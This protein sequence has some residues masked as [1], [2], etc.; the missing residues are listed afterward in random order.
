M[1]KLFI[2]LALAFVGAVPS[3]AQWNTNS[4]PRSIVQTSRYD[5]IAFPRVVRLPDG[6]TW[7]GWRKWDA[8][9][10]ENNK[11]VS[12]GFRNYL[13]LLDKDGNALWDEPLLINDFESPTWM[14]NFDMGALPDGSIVVSTADS[15]YTEQSEEEITEG[16]SR[17]AF[18]PAFYRI[19]QEGNFLWGLNGVE[20]TDYSHSALTRLTV[21]GNDTY[22][23]WLEEEG[24]K[25]GFWMDRIS[26]DGVRQLAAPRQSVGK[27]VATADGNMMAFGATGDGATVM[28]YDRDLQPVWSEPVTYDSY[29]YSGYD[30]DPYQVAIDDEGGAAVSFVRNMGDFTHNVRVQ[31]IGT[32]GEL[33]F[34]LSAIDTYG[35]EEYDHDYTRIALNSETEEIMVDWEDKVEGGA[36]C[37]SLG[38]F[39]YYGDRLYGETGLRLAEKSGEQLSSGYA[40]KQIGAGALP[41][42]DWIVA[43]ADVAGWGN[44][45]LVVRRIDPDG[46]QVWKKTIGRNMDMEVIT[47]I[48]EP[49]ASYFFWHECGKSHPGLN[50]CR[51]FNAKGTYLDDESTGIDSM[52]A[53]QEAEPKA[54]FSLDGKRL[55]ATQKGIN[56]VRYSDGTVQK[57]VRR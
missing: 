25:S 51:I 18:V 16:A 22:V 4:T 54:V 55:P 26:E 46:K 33:G 35:R 40:W 5:D 57:V 3:L 14:S 45:S 7:L 19:D 17:Q 29:S 48:V 10:D 44:M 23:Q 34:G 28:K 27:T 6:K 32:D 21:V 12:L 56:V 9:R 39:N 37:I 8:F 24:A 13:L 38:K 49:K 42:G 52:D 36:E 1:K 47:M 15:R 41:G 31:Y 43:Y 20:Y 2:F 50:I 53:D 30:L 11:A